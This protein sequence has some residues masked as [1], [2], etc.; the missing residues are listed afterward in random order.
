M[1]SITVYLHNSR[2]HIQDKMKKQLILS[3]RSFLEL[4]LQIKFLEIFLQINKNKHKNLQLMTSSK[5]NFKKAK[6]QITQGT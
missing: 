4:F 5:N 1:Y 2:L 6:E 3:T